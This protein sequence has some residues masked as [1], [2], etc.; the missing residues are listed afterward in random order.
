MLM[1]SAFGFSRTDAKTPDHFFTGFPSYWNIVALYLYVLELGP[2]VNAAVVL[3]LA[4]LV[5]VPVGY[6]YPSRTR[7]WQV[8]TVLLGA[9]W[10]GSMVAA[11]WLLPDA[12]RPMVLGSLAF[13][14]YYVA[15]SLA[16]HTRRRA[17]RA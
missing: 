13:P 9:V 10:A 11:A 4:V 14:V 12:P 7:T 17:A 6:V 3:A 1:S 2:A 5:F 16:L 15:L 8:P